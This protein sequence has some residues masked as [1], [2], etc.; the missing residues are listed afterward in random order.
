MELTLIKTRTYNLKP[1]GKF[2]FKWKTPMGGLKPNQIF[3]GSLHIK[4]DTAMPLT[5]EQE[6]E[7]IKMMKQNKTDVLTDDTHFFTLTNDG[8]TEVWHDKIMLYGTDPAFKDEV[9]N[10]SWR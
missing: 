3:V 8:L 10:G 9:D 2:Y 6:K 5:K 4:Y 1:Y 7:V